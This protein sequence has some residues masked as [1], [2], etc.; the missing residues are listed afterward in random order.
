MK[1]A[2]FARG[3]LPPPA[4]HSPSAVAEDSHAAQPLAALPLM[5]A[6]HP[7]RALAG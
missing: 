7:L 6:A 2:D 4:S 1:S 5:D 3:G